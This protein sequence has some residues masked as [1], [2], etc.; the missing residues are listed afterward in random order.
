MY[1]PTRNATKITAASISLIAVTFV[2]SWPVGSQEPPKENPAATATQ[3]KP[4]PPAPSQTAAPDPDAQTPKKKLGTEL[5][6]KSLITNTDLITLTV[7]VTD[8]YGRY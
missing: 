8:T 5:D 6:D 2:I 1:F 4:A 3:D 7:T